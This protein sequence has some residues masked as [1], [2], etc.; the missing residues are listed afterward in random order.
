MTI[1][2]RL[3]GRPPAASL[4][5][6]SGSSR[7]SCAVADVAAWLARRA[8][9]ENGHRGGRRRRGG[10]GAAAR[11]GQAAVRG[12]RTARLRHGDGSAAWLA[13]RGWPEL[14]PLVRDHPVT[15]L[16][17][18]GRRRVG[19]DGVARGADRRL[20]GQARRPAPRAD[21]PARFA[22]WRAPVSLRPGR[23]HD[24]RWTLAG[25]R[26]ADGR[27]RPAPRGRAGTTRSQRGSGRARSH[28]S[29]TYAPP[30]AW[31][32]TPS[33]GCAGPA[34]PCAR[35]RVSGD[36]PVVAYYWGDDGWTID[37]RGRRYR[38]GDGARLRSRAGAVARQPARDDHRRHR[39]ARRD[40]APMFGGGTLAVVTDPGQLLRSK[41]GK[42]AVEKVIATV[43]PGNA[44]VFVEPG[45]GAGSAPPALKALGR[46]GR[47]QGEARGF[48]AP[49]DGELVAWVEGRA[50]EIGVAIEKP[51][52]RELATRVGAFVT[53]GDVDRQ[54]MGAMAV[55]EL[56]KLSL[57]RPDGRDRRGRARARAGGRPGLDVGVPRRRRHPRRS[58]RPAPCWTGSSSRPRSSSC[59]S[60]CTGACEL[61]LAADH[62]AGGSPAALVKLIGGH[63]YKVE[64]TA[65]QARWAP[66]GSRQALEGLLELDAMT[67]GV[68]AAGATDR[69]R[70]MAWVAWVGGPG[71]P[72]RRARR[73]RPRWRLARQ[74]RSRPRV[75]RRAGR[76]ELAPGPLGRD[77]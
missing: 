76:Q 71:R 20:R 26:A 59:S 22:S 15:R 21:G 36:V 42:E 50:A 2:G 57:Y 56:E 16:A 32:R 44:L 54:R 75:R 39:R 63:P 34:A 6:P 51:A 3:R 55:G 23:A 48:R 72:E 45:D 40:R 18:D 70:R 31:R 7:H 19:D 77:V 12:E 9:G 58:P 10:R 66:E 64:K 41:A 68:G 30:P 1:P 24:P 14:G 38:Q 73:R 67:K 5:P 53:E 46:R 8:T 35:R 28:W 52:A 4:E 61:L 74:G 33:G 17:E 37:P 47:A 27:Q 69:Q 13:D 49:Q 65:E 43:A 62:A 25:S 29:A 11:R 60:S